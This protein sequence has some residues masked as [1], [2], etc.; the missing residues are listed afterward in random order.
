MD[1]CN[2]GQE[3]NIFRDGVKGKGGRFLFENDK[4]Q[5]IGHNQHSLFMFVNSFDAKQSVG[6][7][8]RNPGVPKCL[9]FL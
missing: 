4:Q 1:S 9:Y 3:M 6:D 7:Y 2:Q 5:I 8:E